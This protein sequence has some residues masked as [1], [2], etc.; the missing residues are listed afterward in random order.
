MIDKVKAKVKKVI[1][2][3]TEFPPEFSLAELTASNTAKR[4]G[5]ENQPTGETLSNLRKTAY[6]LLDV[7]ALFAS[8]DIYG[9]ETQHPVLVNSGYRSVELNKHI[10]GSSNTSA[11]TLGWAADI[12]VPAFGSPYQV[13]AKIAESGLKFDQLIYEYDSWV[14]ISFDPRMRQ[15][16]LT[17][18]KSGTSTGL[19]L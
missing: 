15:Q 7:R 19:H 8:K 14:H 1:K 5:I 6:K 4:L 13:A 11:H 2:E 17:I 3:A 9:W 18:N 12:R 16:V 10:P